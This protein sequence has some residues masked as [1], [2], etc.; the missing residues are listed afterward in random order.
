MTERIFDT[1]SHAAAFDAVVLSCQP[2][3]GRFAIVLDRTAFFPL[4]GGQQ[5]DTGMLD[6]AHV[7]DVRENCR[8]ITHFADAPLKPGTQVHGIIDWPQRFRRMQNHTGEHIVSGLVHK[9][10]GLENVGFHMGSQDV[11]VDFSGEL[12]RMQLDR[13]ETLA[14][15]AVWNNAIITAWYPTAQELTAIDYRSKLELTENVRIVTIEGYDNCACC[16]PHVTRTGEIGIIKL[17][18]FIRYKG[19]VR[20]HMLCGA[21]ALDDYRLKFENIRDI[22]NSLSVQQADAA[23]AVYALNMQLSN[24]Q[25]SLS[26]MGRILART[27]AQY[28]Q[29][30]DGLILS[31]SESL[32]IDALR[33]FA[34]CTIGKCRLCAAFSG[35]DRQGWNYVAASAELDMRALTKPLN[36]GISGRGG[37]NRLM[38]QGHACATEQEIRS[39]FAAQDWYMQ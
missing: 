11:T 20:I 4:G 15:E 8:V 35:S 6:Q 12:T 30:E 16:A 32:D 36:L 24:T 10:Y 22:S 26:T 29:E 21:D 34:N 17:L 9:L 14:N 23:K 5:P 28:A 39:F 2:Q 7:L 33:E 3:E 13:I 38:I 19:G 18:D 37:G 1:D 31:F 27:M 25:R